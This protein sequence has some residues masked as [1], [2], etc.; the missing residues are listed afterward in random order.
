MSK[1]RRDRGSASEDLLQDLGGIESPAPEV[2]SSLS[3]F[4][5]EAYG[6]RVEP[7][8]ELS[9][10]RV[11]VSLVQIEQIFPSPTQPRRVIP[12]Q[13]RQYWNGRVDKASIGYMFDKWLHELKLERDGEAFELDAYLR[14]TIT[15][16]APLDIESEESITTQSALTTNFLRIVD[17]AAS[18]LRDGLTNPITVAP[19]NEHFYIETG[20]RR[21]WAYQLLSWHFATSR[22]WEK[23]PARIVEQVSLWRQASENNVRSDLNAI[24]KA[25]QF[26]LLLME[27]YQDNEA[28][29]KSLENFRHELDFYAQIADGEIWRVPRGKGEALLNA[30]G[31]SDP[32]QLR[33]YR[34]LLRLPYAVWMIADDLNWSENRIQKTIL[35]NAT[36]EDEIIRAALV[37]AYKDGY[38]VSELTLYGEYLNFPEPAYHG[39]QNPAQ[40][41]F[42]DEITAHQAFKWLSKNASRI[43]TM[44]MPQ[45][46]QAKA[47]IY[48]VRQWLDDVEKSTGME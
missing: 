47:Y 38:T 14:G 29:F 37:Q 13:I 36:T 25:R 6:S 46:Q 5:S 40:Y 42:Q 31:L 48:A 4:A 19:V 10:Q 33:Q 21:W 15:D 24:A 8:P 43:P 23:I 39:F 18:I 35:S 44:G 22:D 17:L 3:T 41:T 9:K 32:V 1:K 26:A 34:R 7:F 45:I 2:S 16:R 12:T 28:H 30:M 20:E 27:L 11:K